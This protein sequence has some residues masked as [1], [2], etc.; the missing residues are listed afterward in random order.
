MV[1]SP[2]QQFPKDVEVRRL[3]EDEPHTPTIAPS[4]PRICW[5]LE[6]LLGYERFLSEAKLTYSNSTPKRLACLP[7]T[8]GL[9]RSTQGRGGRFLHPARPVRFRSWMR[10]SQLCRKAVW[11]A[12]DEGESRISFIL[13]GRMGVAAFPRAFGALPP[14]ECFDRINGINGI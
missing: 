1:S 5:T 10:L 13:R 9:S 6:Q 4:V 3:G 14:K 11:P 8:A 2:S 7:A 12:A